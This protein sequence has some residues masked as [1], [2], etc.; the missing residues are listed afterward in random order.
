[1]R[2]EFG[3]LQELYIH[4]GTPLRGCTFGPILCVTP[5]VGPERPLDMPM[6]PEK[7]QGGVKEPHSA[8]RRPDMEEVTFKDAVEK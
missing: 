4:E 3:G 5:R 1:M 2:S 6:T 7:P 8:T